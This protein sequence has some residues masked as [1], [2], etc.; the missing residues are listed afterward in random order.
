[1]NIVTKNDGLTEALYRKI[2]S[3]LSY[4]SLK[5]FVDNRIKFFKEYILQEP[6]E[7]NFSDSV[8]LGNLVDCILLSPEE[9]D[10]KFHI[11]S[12]KKPS[13]QLGDLCDKMVSLTKKYTQPIN[14]DDEESEMEVTRSFSDIFQEAVDFMKSQ[15]K[16]KGKDTGKILDLYL[17]DEDAEKYY[18][19]HYY[20]AGKIMVETSQVT[21]AQK[22]ADDALNS[23][24][25]PGMILRL[26]TNE[27]V[28]VFNQL[29]I[30]CNLED[31]LFS[32]T[33]ITFEVPLKALLDKVIINHADK[34][35][36]KF[37]LKVTWEAEDFEYN[38]LKMKYYIQLGVYDLVFKSWI[39]KH[40]P[41]LKHYK[42]EPLAFIALDSK[43]VSAPLLYETD[44]EWSRAAIYGFQTA[45][46]KKYK[47]VKEIVEDIN[48]HLSTGNWTISKE[49]YVNNGWTQ[50]NKP[51]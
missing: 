38:F 19:E 16:F 15:D 47:G 25:A 12:A 27:N 33:E 2:K 50:I 46:G 5:V 41:E 17:A 34:T 44:E 36:R 11:V 45:S 1:M 32:E 30:V 31:L 48:H 7:D 10:N 29:P 28:E 3:R 39:K 40:R 42:I 4:S 22:L 14:P 35:I 20:A 9:F 18:E 13:G 8:V 24:F 43:G 21:Y 26:Q 37:D 23:P 51:W 6:R 49:N